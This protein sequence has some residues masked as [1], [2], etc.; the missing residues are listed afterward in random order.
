MN[1]K[2][3]I[4]EI[5]FRETSMKINAAVSCKILMGSCKKHEQKNRSMGCTHVTQIKYTSFR[6]D[7]ILQTS[8]VQLSF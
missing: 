2:I 6:D 5:H 1:E 4:C 3:N 8:F 7:K